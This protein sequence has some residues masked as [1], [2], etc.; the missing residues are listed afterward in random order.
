ML[1]LLFQVSSG[2][3]FVSVKVQ[4][5]ARGYRGH[6]KVLQAY[7]EA[8]RKLLPEEIRRMHGVP[9]VSPPAPRKVES[10]PFSG[11]FD[12]PLR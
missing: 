12:K 8:W 10:S 7:L 6:V 1:S 4:F 5:K 3:T 9:D 2:L 11:H